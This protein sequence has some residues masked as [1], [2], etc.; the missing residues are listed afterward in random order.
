[1]QVCLSSNAGTFSMPTLT[2]MNTESCHHPNS[3]WTLT[4]WS[5]TVPRR[6]VGE[7]FLLVLCPE[8]F[9]IPHLLC[10]CFLL[11][12]HVLKALHI[13][14]LCVLSI[15]SSCLLSEFFSSISNYAEIIYS[16]KSFLKVS[17]WLLA[18]KGLNASV[19]FWYNRHQI[20]QSDH[21]DLFKGNPM[22]PQKPC[23]CRSLSM[24]S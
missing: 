16:C 9:F 17:L 4:L 23:S 2:L 21:P 1:M 8:D 22:F 5:S 19:Q 15:S 13:F 12:A 24:P 10:T 14:F 20:A 11:S 3:L 7:P 6:L 18:K